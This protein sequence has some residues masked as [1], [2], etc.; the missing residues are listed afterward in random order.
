MSSNNVRPDG[1]TVLGVINNGGQATSSSQ[2][3][4]LKP[5]QNNPR[6][7]APLKTLK[8]SRELKDFKLGPTLGPISSSF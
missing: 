1:R 2:F 8:V 4:P 7:R 6:N 5:Q 3:Q